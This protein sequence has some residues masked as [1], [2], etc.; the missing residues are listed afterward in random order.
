MPEIADR[1]KLALHAAQLYYVRDLK[2][3][4]IAHSMNMSRSSV[5]R[6]LSYA[7]HTGLVDIRIKPP[8]DGIA[9][10]QHQIR[11][12]DRAVAYIIPSHPKMSAIERGVRVARHAGRIIPGLVEP[13]MVVGVAWGTTIVGVSRHLNERH[14]ADVSIVQLNGAAYPENFGIGFVGEILDRFAGAFAAR[15]EP[16]P[17]PAFFDD[18]QTRSAMWRE[19]S[20]SRVLA[21]QERMDIAVFGV[22]DPQSDVPGHVYRGGY[23]D[24]ADRATLQAEGV[25]GD[26]ATVF[27]RA[28]GSHEGISLNG[29][30]SGPDLEVL[31]RTPRRVCVVSDPSRIP[32][33][34]AALAADLITDLIIDEQSAR[35]LVSTYVQRD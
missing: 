24:E 5:S 33:L 27:L 8:A 34:R 20:V 29:R 28:D 31:R 22:G 15:A 7:R 23:L 6:L 1:T 9:K 13:S 32:A 17:V 12:R 25:V 26:V 11:L 3:E 2:M 21:L 30:S 16:L 4:A 18:P 35:E 10:L 14:L 19:R